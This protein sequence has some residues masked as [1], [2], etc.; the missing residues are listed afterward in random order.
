MKARGKFSRITHRWMLNKYVMYARIRCEALSMCASKLEAIFKA[1]GVGFVRLLE[2]D[3]D[4]LA[5]YA[6][7]LYPGSPLR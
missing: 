5:S 4:T 2:P 7:G 1:S 6:D 3:P